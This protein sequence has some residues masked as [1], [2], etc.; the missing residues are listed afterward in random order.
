MKK[1]LLVLMALVLTFAMVACTTENVPGDEAGNEVV[2]NAQGE[3]TDNTEAESG[4]LEGDLKEILASVV[5]GVTPEELMVDTIEINDEL[6]PGFFYVDAPAAGYEAYVSAPL[7]G[8]IAHEVSVLRVAEGTDA[9]ALAK[10]IEAGDYVEV[11][12]KEGKNLMGVIKSC[13]KVWKRKNCIGNDSI[14]VIN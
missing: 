2:D 7:I 12:A 11:S 13:V 9:E 8:S 3:N 6:F 4:K 5:N 14:C 1:F 10:E